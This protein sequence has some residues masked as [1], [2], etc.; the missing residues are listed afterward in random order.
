MSSRRVRAARA[1]VCACVLAGCEGAERPSGAHVT[2][3]GSALG[4]EARILRTQ[5]ERFMAENPGI[6]VELRPTP[7]AAD[8]R[9]QLYVQ[10]LNARVDDPD[11]LQLDVIWTPEFAA[12]G[13]I[14]PLDR[15]LP[16][17]D[18][19]FPAAIQANRWSGSLYAMPWFADVGMLY[20]RTDLLDEAPRDFDQLAGVAAL[21]R[22]AGIPFGLVWQGARYEGLV[23][24]FLEHLG[25]FGGEILDERGRVRVDSEPAVRALRFMRASLVSDPPLVPRAALAWHEEETRFAFQNGQAVLMRNW[26]YAFPLMQDSARSSIA[27]RFDVAPMPSAPGGTPTATLGGGQLAINRYSEHPEAAYRLI[28]YLLRPEQ[29]LERARVVGQYP[30]RP[31]LYDDPAAVEAMPVPPASARRIIQHAR[32]R[33][34]TPV[35]TELSQILQ[36]WLHR[37]LTGQLEPEPALRS[38]AREM[39]ALL[40][41]V[42]LAEEAARERD[43]A[44]V[45]R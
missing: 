17:T 36:I 8:Q 32:P 10:W 26:P 20:W 15:F 19:F 21:A 31:S 25:G 41:R 35:Y 11:I 14:L 37:S 13:W 1:F 16:P 18:S 34:V 9:H 22:D 12:A 39:R 44:G 24:V 29:M 4:A 43:A 23:T 2:F 33:P 27:G 38:A 30:T 42:G 28:E 6:S 45:D 7:D 40:D 3:S 5:F